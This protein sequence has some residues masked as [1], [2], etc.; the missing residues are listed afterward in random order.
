MPADEL[1]LRRTLNGRR[2]QPRLR[3]RHRGQHRPA[4]PARRSAGRGARPVL[5]AR[6][7]RHPPASPAARRVRRAGRRSC[8][9]VRAAWQ[10]W[11]DA[12]Q[13]LE[14]LAREI[15]A[16]RRE[17]DYLRHRERELADL[18]AKP[19]EEEEL[20]QS[21]QSLMHQDKLAT[22]LREAVAGTLREAAV[23]SS[24]SVR[25][26]A[27]WSAAPGLAPELLEPAVQALGRALAELGEAEATVEAALRQVLAGCGLAGERRGAAVRVA[28][29]RAQASRAGRRAAGAAGR[30]AGPA[31][32]HRRRCHR[33]GSHGPRGGAVAAVPIWRLRPSCRAG[34]P[35]AAAALAKALAQ[36]AAATE[37]GAGQLPGQR[38]SPWARRRV[39]WGRSGWCSRSAP[40]PASPSAP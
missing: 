14:T 10:A 33:C 26:S 39:R 4:A 13:R 24:G 25:P 11:Q 40:T 19:G 29:R 22:A 23:R 15:E 36:R 32:A 17:E 3:Q 30:D 18:D 27:G 20:A 34:V 16:A 28:R 2:P 5:A 12:V 31:P 37:A 9:A 21:R 1:V 35:V 6:P 7:A 38:W 8:A